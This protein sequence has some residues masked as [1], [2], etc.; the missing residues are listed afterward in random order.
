MLFRS[1]DIAVDA[2]NTARSQFTRIVVGPGRGYEVGELST[3]PMAY[4]PGYSFRFYDDPYFII[5]HRTGMRRNGREVE[6]EASDAIRTA[7]SQLEGENFVRKLGIK[8]PRTGRYDSFTEEGVSFEVVRAKDISQTEATLAHKQVIHQEGRLFWDKRNFE[9]LPDVNNNRAELMD[10]IPALERG[11]GLAV[12]QLTHEDLLKSYKGAF[13]E[14]YGDLVP[15]GDFDIKSLKQIS[16]D[17]KQKMRVVT[18]RT[19][20]R[21]VREAR[22][23]IEYFRLIEGTETV[24]IPRLREMIIDM[25]YTTNRLLEPIPG[26]SRL[27]GAVEKYAQTMDPIRTMRSIAF[28]TF[29]VF[30]PIR[31]ALLQSFQISYLFALDPL[32]IASPR[33]FTDAAML[34]R[35][36]AKRRNTA[37]NDGYSSKR[38]AKLMGLSEREYRELVKRF[39]RSGL[40]DLVN[41]HS[42]TGGS[43]RFNKQALPQGITGHVGY[44]SKQLAVGV[45]DFFQKWGF[46]WGEKNNLSFT[47]LVALRRYMKGRNPQKQKIKS[48]FDLTDKQWDAIALDASNLA[49][50]MVRPNNFGYQSGLF[51][52]GTQFISFSHKALL[53]MLGQNPAI[54]PKDSL[55]IVLGGY[56]LF[57]ANMFGARDWVEQELTEMGVADAE[58][59]G[60]EGGTL[61]D[62]LSAGII[63]TAWNKIQEVTMEDAKPLDLEFLAPGVGVTG[64][65]IENIVRSPISMPFGAFGNIYSKTLESLEYANRYAR[66]KPDAPAEDK[67]LQAADMMMRGMFPQYNDVA[68]AHVAWQMNTWYST[69]A[70]SL[71]LRPTMNTLISRG[72]FGARSIEEVSYYELQSRLYENE[73]E[74]REFEEANK[75]FLRKNT[76]LYREGQI[77]REQWL[78]NAEMLTALMEDWPEG[79]QTIIRE[80]SFLTDLEN[81]DSSPAVQL[82]EGIEAGTVRPDM[83]H[84]IDNMVDIPPDQRERIKQMNEEA[85]EQR[86]R[87]DTIERG[88]EVEQ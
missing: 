25:A 86:K 83:N 15:R 12:R 42:F 11:T 5:K 7:G 61:V 54:A 75:K 57:G 22:E 82:L 50:G 34:R 72:L 60:I 65:L 58:I 81:G 80:R 31:Q 29:M 36:I 46:D 76:I 2:A 35:G 40:L 62:L 70:E 73:K 32:Y 44:R 53:G 33:L 8:N 59:P 21:R 37:F 85:W 64:M 74:M 13:I 52:L 26:I 67:F 66:G 3:R 1:I 77:T 10:F 38:A 24:A 18:D 78:E 14:E 68:M 9:R 48:I 28:H 47:F 30:R 79:V 87:R 17:L 23:I 71:H 6:G 27:A 63:E 49:L 19:A 55:K 20:R 88:E 69:S 4:Y 41:V 45:R 84:L 43:R 56:L 51:S 39:D 16:D